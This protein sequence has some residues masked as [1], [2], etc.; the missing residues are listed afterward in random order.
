MTTTHR[1]KRWI[2]DWRPEDEAFWAETGAK[3]AKRNLG[4]SIFAEHLGFSIWLLWSV[5]TPYLISQNPNFNFTFA[6]LF[7]LTALPNLLGSLL[8][9][10]YT[11]AVPKFGGR[12]W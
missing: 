3:V 2:D 5:A 12:N 8:R 10:P 11:F 1:T 9:I 6:Q 7:L 4:W